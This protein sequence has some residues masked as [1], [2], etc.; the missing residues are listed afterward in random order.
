MS[1]YHFCLGTAGSALQGLDLVDCSCLQTHCC[2]MTSS[3]PDQEVRD[4]DVC[5]T[6]NSFDLAVSQ[7]ASEQQRSSIGHSSRLPEASSAN[8]EPAADVQDKATQTPWDDFEDACTQA[9]NEPFRMTTP[10]QVAS[11]FCT[12]SLYCQSVSR[13]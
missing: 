10:L 6:L 8:A 11:W 7:M 4:V 1:Q 9:A 12:S 13:L 3:R 5:H 2:F